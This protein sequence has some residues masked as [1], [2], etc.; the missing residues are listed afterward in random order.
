[1]TNQGQDFAAQIAA[2]AARAERM[3]TEIARGT[4]QELGERIIDNTPEDTGLARGN[5]MCGLGSPDMSTTTAKGAEASKKRLA[6]VLANYEAKDGQSI[7]ISNAL[8]YVPGLEYGT[9]NK[10]PHAMVRRAAAGFEGIVKE[11][12]RKAG[13]KI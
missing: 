5:W 1:M 11:Q 3:V 7:H 12:A 8:P 6:R 13:G 4:A 10:T 2:W 9:A